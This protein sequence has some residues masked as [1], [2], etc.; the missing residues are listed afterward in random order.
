V[1]EPQVDEP[2]DAGGEED[3][4]GL[5]GGLFGGGDLFGGDDEF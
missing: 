1:D 2:M 5:F 3:E 4:G